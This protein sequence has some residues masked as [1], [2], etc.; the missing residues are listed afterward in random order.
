MIFLSS[1]EWRNICPDD[2]FN[3]GLMNESEHDFWIS[4]EDLVTFFDTIY[5]AHQSSDTMA[6]DYFNFN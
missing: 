2:I 1:H 6:G 3:Y 5:I 4:I